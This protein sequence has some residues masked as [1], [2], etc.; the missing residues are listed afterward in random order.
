VNYTNLL[1]NAGGAITWD[2]PIQSTG[3]I[4]PEFI[5]QLKLVGKTVNDFGKQKQLNNK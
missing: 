4:Y 1:L 2:V 5:E 3:K